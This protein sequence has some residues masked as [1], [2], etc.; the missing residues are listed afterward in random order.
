[1]M[2]SKIAVIALV[3]VIAVPILLGYAFNLTETTETD[4]RTTGDSVNVTP[5]LQNNT[6]YNYVQADTHQ[7][8]TDFSIAY[9]S[10]IDTMPA[11][12]TITTTKSSLKD[13]I[14]YASGTNI[15]SSGALISAYTQLSYVA[16]YKMSEGYIIL[17]Y[18]TTDNVNH[19]LNYFHS[20]DHDY[21]TGNTTIT[22][23]MSDNEISSMSIS[24]LKNVN[25]F[26]KTGSYNGTMYVVYNQNGQPHYVDLSGGFSLANINNGTYSTINLPEHTKSF[27]MSVN[28]DSI[29]DSDYTFR[30]FN[31]MTKTYFAKTTVDGVPHWQARIDY[32]EIIDLYYDPSRNDNTYQIYME[33][34]KVGEANNEDLYDC[35]VELR[36]VG[37]WQKLIGEA[38]VYQTYSGDRSSVAIPRPNN[39]LDFVIVDSQS[40]GKFYTPTIRMDSATYRGTVMSVIGDA[41]YTPA[42]F[43][44]NPATTIT[45]IS[46]YGTS[47]TFG[48]NT[49]TVSKEGKITIGGHDVPV[50]DLVFSSVPDGNGGY[51][52]KIGN[53]FI[54]NSMTPSTIGLNGLWA[55]SVAT[56]SMESYT[57]THTE[58]N[59][60]SFGWDGVDQNFLI[61][62]LITCLGVFIA[63]GIYAR[64]RGTGGII[65]LMIVVG[66][67]AMVFFVML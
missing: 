28:L 48:G 10:N 57:Y 55:A 23:Y 15:I 29:T 24:N 16:S 64:K 32:G 47:L 40:A 2:V 54:S 19:T 65:P 50:K 51:D 8:N 5:L 4:Y 26:T 56:S 63:L 46:K 58:W 14:A 42:D 41:T 7:I 43:R 38:N 25:G 62:G 39:G 66:G 37:G 36:Y 44:Q 12:K 34:E 1:M 45:N 60:G 22:Y 49:Y 18:L 35:H 6:Y 3:A 61:V 33:V 27:I 11:Y 59:A 13:N 52:N 53:T 20:L 9:N 31:F 21:S 30:I 67:A 17:S